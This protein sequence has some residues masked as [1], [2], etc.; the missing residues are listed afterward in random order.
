MSDLDTARLRDASAGTTGAR[1]TPS[2]SEPHVR[3]SSVA[4]VRTRFVWLRSRLWLLT[5]LVLAAILIAPAIRRLVL[6]V[7]VTPAQRGYEVAL[8]SGCF[9]CHGANG[10]GGIKN[11]GS[12]D[13][14]VPGFSGGTPMMWAK[15]EPELREYILDGA[16]ARKLADPKYKKKMEAQLLAMPAYRGHLSERQVDDLLSY[17]RAASGLITPP[18]ALAAQGQDLAIRLGCFNCHGPMGAGTSSN[19][20]SF[21]GYIPGWWGKDFRD[22]V[23]NDDELRDWILD[24]QTA[25]LRNNPI[26]SYFMRSQRVSMPAYRDFIDDKQLAALMR[27]VRWV[28]EGSWQGKPLDL[29]H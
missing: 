7:E 27:Y 8:R 1:A 21:K 19:P 23:R 10:A 12:E 18:D 6:V 15:S 20:G 2:R 3:T 17:I 14:E 5:T 16:P 11:P 4:G 26:A 24:G 22:L 28:N 13:E 9:N 29:G 25:R